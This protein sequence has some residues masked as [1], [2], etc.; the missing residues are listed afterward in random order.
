MKSNKK[1]NYSCSA[2]L[3]VTLLIVFSLFYNPVYGSVYD[4]MNVGA[5]STCIVPLV[6]LEDGINKTSIIYANN[7]SAKISIDA[8]LTQLTYNYS[9]NIVNKNAS[10]WQV[11]LEYF[12]SVNISRVNATIILHNNSTAS[13]QIAINSQGIN[14]TNEYYNLTDNA[15]IHIGVKDL[16]ENSSSG[17]TILDVYLRLKTPNTTTYTLYII[18]FEFT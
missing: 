14:Q 17:K 15:V 5:D 10:L 13:N 16:I 8:N 18:T 12:E 1:T 6:V 3:A 4:F 2:L 11:K 7:T 9:L